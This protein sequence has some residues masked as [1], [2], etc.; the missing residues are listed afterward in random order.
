[1]IRDPNAPLPD[2]NEPNEPIVPRVFLREPGWKV[3]MK[4]GSDREFCHN[5]APGEDAYHRLSDGELFIYSP[6]E[7]LCLPCADRRGLLHYE[8]KG[9]RKP[10]RTL[11]VGGPAQPGETFIMRDLLSAAIAREAGHDD[12]ENDWVPE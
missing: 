3:A 2:R 6:D 1:M 5:I 7:R 11:E 4:V 9:L 8:P 12:Y 10:M